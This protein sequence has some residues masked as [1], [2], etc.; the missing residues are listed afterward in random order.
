MNLCSDCFERPVHARGLCNRCYQMRKKV[1]DLP[2]LPDLRRR[3]K[4]ERGIA[5]HGTWKPARL[6]LT[7]LD[8]FSSKR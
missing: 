6:R 3:P 5:Y 8:I 4:N 1:A 7:P 2:E